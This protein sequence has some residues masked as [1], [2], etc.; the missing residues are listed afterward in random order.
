MS[1]GSIEGQSTDRSSSTPNLPVFSIRAMI[2]AR[3][4]TGSRGHQDQRLQPH[5]Q[6]HRKLR[7]EPARSRSSLMAK[8]E[9]TA[10]GSSARR[11][12]RSPATTQQRVQKRRQRRQ[13]PPPG[14]RIEYLIMLGERVG[15]RR[16]T[17]F[18]SGSAAGAAADQA[19]SLPVP[20]GSSPLGASSRSSDR[21]ATRR[22]FRHRSGTTSSTRRLN[23]KRFGLHLRQ[24]KFRQGRL[25]RFQ[26]PRNRTELQMVPKNAGAR[27]ASTSATSFAHIRHANNFIIVDSS[28]A[29]RKPASSSKQE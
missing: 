3:I 13:P 20:H 19:G 6:R 11:S 7:Q 9:N 14:G 21:T 17:D 15:S 5:D 23:R 26:G 29:T 28:Q 10:N 8:E 18:A 1:S 4:G 22:Q 25:R 24:Q 2:F 16:G 27:R 12:R